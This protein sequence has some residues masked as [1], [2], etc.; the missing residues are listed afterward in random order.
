MSNKPSFFQMIKNFGSELT[1]HIKNGAAIV[2][3]PQYEGRLQE[4]DAC[5]HLIREEMRCGLCGCYVEH[6]A[7][8]ESASCPDNRWSKLKIGENGKKLNLNG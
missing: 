5:P 8:W 6:K 1:E 2:T 7:K 3:T 4:C